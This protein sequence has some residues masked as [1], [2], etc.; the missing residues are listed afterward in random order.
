VLLNGVPGKVFHCR[1][2]DPLSPLLFVLVADLLQAI[3]NK[4]MTNEI[5]KLP[6]DVGCTNDF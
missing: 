6:I 1:Q 2:G 3:V 5:L 4:A